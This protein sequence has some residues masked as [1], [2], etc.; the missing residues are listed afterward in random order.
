MGRK[1]DEKGMPILTEF[2][3]LY[4]RKLQGFQL[5][6]IEDEEFI[7][8]KEYL[9]ECIENLMNVL[10]DEGK[11]AFLKYEEAES[12]V[13]A[14]MQFYNFKKGYEYRETIE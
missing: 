3:E 6:K 1:L 5:D 12:G 2:E 7:E 9:N 13:E 14:Y 10:T 11:K 4:Y 8:R